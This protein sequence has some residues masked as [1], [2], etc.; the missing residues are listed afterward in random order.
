MLLIMRSQVFKWHIIIDALIQY[1][2]VN[3]YKQ[4]CTK[5]RQEDSIWQLRL[6]SD[7]KL[8]CNSLWTDTST[9]MFYNEQDGIKPQAHFRLLHALFHCVV[10]CDEVVRQLVALAE[11][12]PKVLW[13]QLPSTG[14]NSGNIQF[15]KS[16]VFHSLRCSYAITELSH[17]TTILLTNSSI[18]GYNTPLAL[19]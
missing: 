10:R 17:A 19:R 6:N 9:S 15:P 1:N 3:L 13:R 8:L 18:Y 12:F 2:L 16:F 4:K 5:K 11:C 7:N 14:K